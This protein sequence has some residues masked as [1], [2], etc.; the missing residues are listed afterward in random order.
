M[1]P[2]RITIRK[3]SVVYDDAEQD[4]DIP[5]PPPA[6]RGP[7]PR[8]RRPRGRSVLA[9]LIAV[10]A[11][12]FIVFRVVPHAP[13]NRAVVSGWQ[14]TLHVTRFEGDL[15][16]GVTFVARS[17][18]SAVAPSATALV[19]VQGTGKQVFLAGDLDRSPMTLRGRFAGSTE[20][21]V[22]QADVTV[23]GAHVLLVSRVPAAQAPAAPN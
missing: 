16:V 5:R 18:P 8:R 10:A 17:R 9:P 12:I 22:V 21:Q 23:A 7:A 13:P 15:L 14:V 6:R 2:P 4:R 20:A 3:G 19:A 11:G 1:K